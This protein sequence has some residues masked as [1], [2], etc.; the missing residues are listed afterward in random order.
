MIIGPEHLTYEKRMKDLGL[1]NLEKGK[2]RG[3]LIN[4]CECLKGGYQEDGARFCSGVSSN[5][6][7]GKGQK[8]MHRR[9]HLNMRENF[10]TVKVTKHWNRLH[11]EIVGNSLNISLSLG[12]FKPHLD[13]ILFNFL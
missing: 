13:V 9:F 3:D 10:F 4:I 5:R 7:R 11:K 8:L 6:T 12:I 2:L 1:F